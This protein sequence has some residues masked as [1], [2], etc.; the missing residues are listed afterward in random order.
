MTASS[1]NQIPT[2]VA[3]DIVVNK[4]LAYLFV[5]LR[6]WYANS[7]GHCIPVSFNQLKLTDQQGSCER[8][9]ED[10]VDVSENQCLFGLK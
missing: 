9:S 6:S 3:F 10:A 8:F 1:V 5:Q 4:I 7:L 2:T